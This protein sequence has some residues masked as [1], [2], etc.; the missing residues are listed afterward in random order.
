MYITV[1]DRR[2]AGK[3]LAMIESFIAN[4]PR[5]LLKV[6]C[7]GAETAEIV[8]K[9]DNNRHPTVTI[10]DIQDV[11][12]EV[13]EHLRISRGYR[14]FCWSLSAY[15]TNREL[16]L[17]VPAVTYLD[18]DLYFTASVDDVESETRHCSIA[19]IGHRF[20]PKFHAFAV[21]GY[22]NVQWIFFRNDTEGRICNQKWLQQCIESTEYIPH[23]GIV[24]DQK[25]LDE[26]P[27]T[28]QG[29]HEINHRGVGVGPWNVAT[30]RISKN[31]LGWSVEETTRL[32]F[33]HF[34]GLQFVQRGRVIPC[35]SEFLSQPEIPLALYDEYLWNI[36][37]VEGLIHDQPPE[38]FLFRRLSLSRVRIHELIS[39]LRILHK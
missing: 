20:S 5:K 8:S 17:G 23:L 4:N 9:W 31:N 39:G 2:Y 34:Q 21:N 38:E 18:A 11:D 7:L 33:Y 15:L 30:H 6:Y 22:F 19:A 25:Y 3:G 27:R 12:D 14:E 32:I 16:K 37:K 35:G 13:L 10:A 26:W 24:G 29:F 1:F 28:Y 36:S